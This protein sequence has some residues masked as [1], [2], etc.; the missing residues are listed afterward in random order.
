MLTRSPK[1][2][3]TI[4]LD[5]DGVLC[6]FVSAAM[7]VFGHEY[8]PQTWPPRQWDIAP[9]VG[10]DTVTFWQRINQLGEDFWTYLQPYPWMRDLVDAVSEFARPIILTSPSRS[11]HC[12][13]GK[14]Q[15]LI[16]NGL[17]DL[18]AAYTPLKHHLAAPGRILIDDSAS[19][20][21]KFEEAGGEVILFPQ[22]WNAM[23]IYTLD[24]VDYVRGHLEELTR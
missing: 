21:R 15:W 2:S 16:N 3:T 18:Q 6:D 20:G 1:P 7:A 23:G 5:M 13:S 8:N 14:R 12:L 22:P 19:N 11:P 17:G 9:I 24:V 10:V 4:Y